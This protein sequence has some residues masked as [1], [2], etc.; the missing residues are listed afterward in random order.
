MIFFKIK[1]KVLPP[2]STA[3]TFRTLLSLF[4]DNCQTITAIDIPCK[5][6]QV[7][8]TQAVKRA[9]KLAC[10]D[11]GSITIVEKRKK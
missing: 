2:S 8:K 6:K 7:L 5:F 4:G 9:G 11:L 3:T 10:F 1:N